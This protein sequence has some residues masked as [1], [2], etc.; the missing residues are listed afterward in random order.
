MKTLRMLTAAAVAIMLACGAAASDPAPRG[1]DLDLSAADRA[2]LRDHGPVRVGV[3][4]TA[5]P[6][7][8]I[9]SEDGEH[10]GIT[11]DYLDLLSAHGAFPIER[12]R[13]KTFPEAFDALQ[14]GRVDLLGSMA[15]TPAREGVVRFTAPYA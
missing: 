7:Y 1:R 11:A 3:S 2:W 9:I 10:R 4:D 8:D 13:F 15:R 12:I 6:P 5:W 14:R